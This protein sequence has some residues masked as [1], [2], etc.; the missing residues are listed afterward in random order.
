[1]N[2][3][4]QTLE[5]LSLILVPAQDY[6]DL[7][8]Y[9][10]ITSDDDLRAIIVDGLMRRERR[11]IADILINKFEY[12]TRSEISRNDLIKLAAKATKEIMSGE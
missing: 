11:R 10:D 7:A 9:I 6:Y 1:M 3:D 4:R 5:K 8:D 2:L 12:V